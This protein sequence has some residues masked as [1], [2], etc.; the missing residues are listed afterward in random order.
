MEK[1][2]SF[3]TL[4]DFEISKLCEEGQLIKMNFDVFNLFTNLLRQ[5]KNSSG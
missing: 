3:G 2:L 1:T 4:A 5:K